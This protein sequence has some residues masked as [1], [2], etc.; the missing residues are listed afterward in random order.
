MRNS[1]IQY[2]RAFQRLAGIVSLIRMHSEPN[3]IRVLIPAYQA[4]E[5]LTRL[6]PAIGG[7]FRAEHILTVDDGSGDGTA[8][9]CAEAGISCL[10]FD[11]NR[12]KG[13]A[14]KAGF[15]RLL[16][17]QCAWIITMD[18]DGQH[19]PED[20][21]FLI[22]ATRD[23]PDSG[24]IIGSRDRSPKAMPPARIISN[25]LTSWGLSLLTGQHIVDS[26]SGYRAYAARF[27][28][29][30]SFTA[31]RF[32]MESEAIIRAC[33]AGFS[34]SFVPV[35]TLYCSHQSHISHLKD[36]IRW[37]RS[38]LAVWAECRRGRQSTGRL[39]RF[40]LL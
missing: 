34:V 35:Q 29:H 40:S 23:N 14:L 20:L 26:Q 31:D 19:A 39:Q 25:S 6:I 8:D 32:A 10:R 16:E 7:Y 15:N 17:Q 37:I 3:D 24:I 22:Q 28:R 30:V 1:G 33:A 27:L 5:S 21:P 12:G 13:A 9:I 38:T 36:T 2:P 4:A 11:I 18:A